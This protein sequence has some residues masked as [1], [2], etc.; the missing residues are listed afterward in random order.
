[1]PRNLKIYRPKKS[2][3]RPESPTPVSQSKK[4]HLLTFSVRGAEKGHC[5]LATCSAS[6]TQPCIYFPDSES[7]LLT[8]LQLKVI[9][10]GKLVSFLLRN[11]NKIHIQEGNCHIFLF[12]L[13]KWDHYQI[14]TTISLKITFLKGKIVYF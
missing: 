14:Q 12:T 13:R 11:Q 1:M 3:V 6:C 10:V 8:S 9:K 7:H 5:T 2:M 4:K